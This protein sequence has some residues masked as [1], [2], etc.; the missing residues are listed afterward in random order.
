MHSIE[1]HST[2]NMIQDNKIKINVTDETNI[3]EDS[4]VQST[5]TSTKCHELDND[6]MSV[7]LNQLE[8]MNSN[9][10][11]KFDVQNSKF[12]EQNIKF[13]ELKNLINETNKHVENTNEIFKNNLNKLDQ[14]IERMGVDVINTCLLYTSRCV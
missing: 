10:N 11:N 9:F 5:P 2:P 6:M 3:T 1:V 13:D 8:K 4:G 12:D 7:I 14:N